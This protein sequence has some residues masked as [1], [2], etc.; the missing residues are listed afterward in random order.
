MSIDWNRNQPIIKHCREVLPRV[1]LV[2]STPGHGLHGSGVGGYNDR[3]TKS[4]S[5]SFH[6][7][8]RAADMASGF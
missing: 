6:S 7:T 5:I 4:G 1:F 8:G 2:L 3:L